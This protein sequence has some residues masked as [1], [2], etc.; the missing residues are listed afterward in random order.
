MA[1]PVL[2]TKLYAPALRRELVPRPR[3]LA[4][5]DAGTRIKLILVAAPA[6]YGK[7]TL[8]SSWL[9]QS[10][11]PSTW[12]S[13]DEDDNDP[14]RFFQYFVLALQRIAPAIGQDLLGLPQ[15]ART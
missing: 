9:H 11:I 6:G 4:S 2:A 7:T 10:G 13:L 12:L 1:A 3:L 15:G 14:I 8:V 5:L